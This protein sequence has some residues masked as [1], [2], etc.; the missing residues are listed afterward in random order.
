MEHAEHLP[1]ARCEVVE[2]A[3]AVARAEA[4]AFYRGIGYEG[5][6]SALSQAAERVIPALPI[7]LIE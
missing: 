5:I 1:A 7:I 6:R 2:L 4:H 3:S